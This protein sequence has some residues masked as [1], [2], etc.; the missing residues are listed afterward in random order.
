MVYGNVDVLGGG[1]YSG[2]VGHI[3]LCTLLALIHSR[4]KRIISCT[5]RAVETIGLRLLC[6]DAIDRGSV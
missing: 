6:L 5:V 4:T 3:T 1:L 2:L